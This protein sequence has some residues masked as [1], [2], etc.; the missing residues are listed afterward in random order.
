MMPYQLQMQQSQASTAEVAFAC[1]RLR[2]CKAGM[3]HLL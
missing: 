3:V 1:K 2:D